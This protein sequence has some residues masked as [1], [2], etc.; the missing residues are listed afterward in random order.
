MRLPFS[1]P[2]ATAFLFAT[3]MGR[4]RSTKLFFQELESCEFGDFS[5]FSKLVVIFL[6]DGITTLTGAGN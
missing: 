4:S 5:L 1:R 2:N 6:E 3:A